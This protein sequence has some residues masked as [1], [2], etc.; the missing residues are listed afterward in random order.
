MAVLMNLS[1]AEYSKFTGH[2]STAEIISPEIM[3]HDFLIL[4]PRYI[5]DFWY[6]PVIWAGI[7]WM[8]IWLYPSQESR[9]RKK[10][11]IPANYI[12]D[13]LIFISIA[14]L[15]VIGIR[16]GI[17]RYPLSVTDAAVYAGCKYTSL[18][19][20][21]PFTFIISFR[22]EFSDRKTYYPD[23][24][25]EQIYTTVSHFD[26]N[27][28][29]KKN[30]VI[31][32]L[33]SCGK[34]YTGSLSGY[35]TYTPFLDSLARQSL[36]F[37]NARANGRSSI[38]AIPAILAA[39]PRLSDKAFIGRDNNVTKI[40]SLASALKPD[41]YHT[42]FFHGGT[43]GAMGYEKF[44]TFAGFEHYY[45]M[46]EYPDKKDYDRGWGIWDEE[47]LQFACA[48]MT[49][50]PQPF[51]TGI[52]TLSAHHPYY[53]PEKYR[54]VFPAEKNPILST[55]RYTD[56]ALKRFFISASQQPWYANTLFI[57][58]ADHTSIPF[59]ERYHTI[60]ARYSIPMLFFSPSDTLLKGISHTLVQQTDIF[61]SALDYLG[62]NGSIVAFGKSVFDTTVTRF[63][64]IFNGSTYMVLSDS[65]CLLSN[66]REVT[67][68]YN[69]STDTLMRKDI[70][71]QFPGPAAEMFKALKAVIQ[72]YHNRM[73]GNNMVPDPNDS[74]H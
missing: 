55:I 41:N 56:Y 48:T 15:S 13:S 34:E 40:N 59:H 43:E 49:T 32:I 8:M 72:Q 54:N 27:E 51:I 63:A 1:D 35:D 67:E 22:N 42:S 52:F 4:L 10:Q 25:L 28:P 74:C 66:E 19:L 14:I 38:D 71:R 60:E 33:E 65:L 61:P 50:F 73:T 47:Y 11:Y 20:N 37:D 36:V 5:F 46:E 12:T 64:T 21:T 44:L 62:Y 69:Y 70:S 31:I 23:E 26:H 58:T 30:V 53:I 17:R 68:L 45:G 7:T 29:A 16:G 24:E 2:R 6:I 57:I 39:I 3:G 9:H 18:V